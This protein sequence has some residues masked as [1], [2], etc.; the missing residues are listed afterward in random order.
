MVQ[1]LD[2]TGQRPCP[3]TNYRDDVRWRDSL[4]DI[5]AFWWY[6]QRGKISWSDLARSWL[7]TDCHAYFASDD[8]GP[9]LAHIQGGSY[10][11]R[12]MVGMVKR[13]RKERVGVQPKR[14][15]AESLEIP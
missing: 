8:V 14:R 13:D 2:V 9:A 7:R 12:V 10:P 15:E 5:Q 3:A 11:A 1:Y 6:H 4:E